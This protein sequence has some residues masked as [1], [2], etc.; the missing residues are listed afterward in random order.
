MA[1]GDEAGGLTP[2]SLADRRLSSRR[3]SLRG[4]TVRTTR[5]RAGRRKRSPFPPAYLLARSTPS[6]RSA[7]NSPGRGRG[8]VGRCR[9][10]GLR[11]AGAPVGITRGADAVSRMYGALAAGPYDEVGAPTEATT[12]GPRPVAPDLGLVDEGVRHGL[13]RRPERAWRS[14][15]YPRRPKKA[16][17][18]GLIARPL[19]RRPPHQP[20]S[21][22]AILPQPPRTASGLTAAR[23]TQPGDGEPAGRRPHGEDRA[24]G[25]TEQRRRSAVLLR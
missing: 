22:A 12:R 16:H 24:G 4:S 3:S 5:D 21:R 25:V 2:Q 20:A 6:S 19:A 1:Q 9:G 7:K 17:A 8:P 13:Q 10:S 14:W 11:D 18:L 15:R 23:T